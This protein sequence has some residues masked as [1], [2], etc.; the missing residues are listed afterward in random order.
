MLTI[1]GYDSSSEISTVAS[2]G[3]TILGD[4]TLKDIKFTN[5]L[6]A[7]V[8]LCGNKFVVGENVTVSGSHQIA[9]GANY[10]KTDTGLMYSEIYSGTW[11]KL[12]I[13]PIAASSVRTITK[14]AYMYLDGG[15]INDLIIGGDGWSS[16]HKG[17]NFAAN[18]A[19]KADSG[20]LKKIRLGIDNYAPSFA[21]AVM[22]IL[23]NGMTITTVDSTIENM[24]TDKYLVYSAEG[25]Y[26]DFVYENGKTVAGKFK[27]TPNDGK[28]AVI[29][30]GENKKYVFTEAEVTLEK[31]TTNI[32]YG[33][34]SDLDIAIKVNNGTKEY[35]FGVEDSVTLTVGGTVSFPESIEKSGCLFGGWYSD[36]ALTTPIANGSTITAGTT[37]YAKWIELDDKDLFV[38]GVQIRFSA[39]TGL[40][41][42]NNITHNTRSAIVALNSANSALDPENEA[43]NATDGISYGS[44]VLPAKCLDG[45]KLEKDAVHE[46]NG[47]NYSQR[48]FP[49]RT[50]LK[51]LPTMTDTPQCSSTF[52]TTT[53]RPI[54]LFVRILH[55]PTH[56]V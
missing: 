19:V 49:Q 28:Y 20:T 33:N 34:S 51:L 37:V 48:L 38:E 41:F 8:S 21:G 55:T 36:E 16:S 6:Y 50:S 7:W 44:I 31:G 27:I 39:P 5:G 45:N 54:T 24:T 1:S 53:F 2:G 25:G 35:V 42:V 47:K 10:S 26:V 17:I 4:I 3:Y 32:T 30:N 15:V 23:N 56:R 12:A 29:E 18:V 11:N 46:Y 22:F 13:G 14:D 9:L 43:F 52:P 40:R